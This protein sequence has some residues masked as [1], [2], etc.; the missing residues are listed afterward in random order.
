MYISNPFMECFEMNNADRNRSVG[1]KLIAFR[2]R[3]T[4]ESNITKAISIPI[5]LVIFNLMPKLWR[6][7]IIKFCVLCSH[8]IWEMKIVRILNKCSWITLVDGKMVKVIK[9]KKGN[10]YRSIVKRI[11][12]M[13]AVASSAYKIKWAMW[14]FCCV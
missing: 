11:K 6:P 12:C 4:R 7:F 14:L 8:L 3:Q 5:W 2:K 13:C 10:T 9:E 1:R